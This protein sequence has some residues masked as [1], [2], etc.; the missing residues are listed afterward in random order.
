MTLKVAQCQTLPFPH[1]AAALSLCGIYDFIAARDAHPSNRQIYDDFTNTAFGP[2]A[3][4]NW[5]KGSTRTD[6]I[7]NV[8]AVVLAHS[9][10][11]TLVEWEQTNLMSEVLG[12][13]GPGLKSAVIEIQ[14]DHREIYEKGVEVARAVKKTL[15]L[16]HE[17]S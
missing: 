2:E 8:K 6:R 4:G 15:K 17:V 1:P 10:T 7:T 12:A 5:D 11:D 14:G 13:M 16:L 9:R 3:D